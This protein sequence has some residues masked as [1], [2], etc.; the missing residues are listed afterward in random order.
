MRMEHPS[1][2]SDRLEARKR[3]RRKKRSGVWF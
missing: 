3:K 2:L 1:Q